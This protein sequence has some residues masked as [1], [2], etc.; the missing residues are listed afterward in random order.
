MEKHIYIVLSN[1]GTV[2]S[3]LIQRFG[4]ID[5]AHT[6][7][8]LIPDLSEMYSFGRIFP[9]NPFWGGFVVEDIH[10]GVY[11]LSNQVSCRVLKIPVNQGQYERILKELS[12]FK[13]HPHYRYNFI[14]LL[15]LKIGK[16]IERERAYFC[17]Q[18]VYTILYNSGVIDLKK[19]P[20]LVTPSDFLS[21]EDSTISYDGF[22]TKF[23][24]IP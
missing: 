14:G 20:G 3:R 22:L 12:Q 17:S 5:Y 24:F 1:T 9:R 19:P 16:P 11:L 6:S 21:L 23:N 15:G 10:K 8:S 2:L 4:H 13:E 7:L 18:F